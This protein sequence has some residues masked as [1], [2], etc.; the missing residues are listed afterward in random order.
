MRRVLVAAAAVCVLTGASA[1]SAQAYLY[2]SN[3]GLG[4]GTGTTIGRADLDG[5]GLDG[6][7]VADASGQSGIAVDGSYIYWANDGANAIGRANLDGSDPDPTF[8]PNATSGQD[9][10]PAYVATDGTYIYWTDGQRY[11][12][13]AALDGSGAKPHFLDVGSSSFPN[14]IAVSSGVVY[15]A[16]A[17]EIVSLQDS[18][19]SPSVQVVTMVDTSFIGLAI[20]SDELYFSEVGSDGEGIWSASTSGKGLTELT[21]TSSFPGAIATDGTYLYWAT[22]TPSFD[23]GTIARGLLT[24]S[25]LTM[26]DPTFISGAGNP[27]GVAVDKLIDPT[28]TTASCL[29]AEVAT[30]SASTCTATVNDSAS[31]S[32]PTGT[33]AFNGS[34]STFFSGSSSSC[35]LQA[36]G[37]GVATCT[38]GAVSITPGPVTI[39]AAY[40]GDPVHEASSASTGFCVGTATQ[41]GGSTTTTST[42]TPPPP[43]PPPPPPATACVVPKLKG[44]SLSAARKRIAAAHCALGKVSKPRVRKH[45]KLGKLVVGSTKPGVGTK[46]G[47]DAKVAVKLV[48]APK[49]N[50]RR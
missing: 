18:A 15:V 28:E 41:C 47:A 20:L 10:A 33:V 4:G 46:L 39:S 17:S 13:R 27:A 19:G 45:H 24:S 14:G 25:G 48:A 43:P 50:R 29:P 26:V 35:T 9:A 6:S 31:S 23:A 12:G 16:G 32:P 37:G 34:V 21:G 7:F 36:Q 44:S 11:V 2:W 30:G 49:K 42:S 8:I 22:N 3:A 1:G 40:G 38:V 5:S